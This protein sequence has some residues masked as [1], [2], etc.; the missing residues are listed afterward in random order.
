[1]GAPQLPDAC[2]PGPC[3]EHAAHVLACLSCVCRYGLQVEYLADPD[4]KK[5]L[6]E[7][8]ERT[9]VQAILLGTRKC[10]R[11]QGTGAGT[12]CQ[13]TPGKECGCTAG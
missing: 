5:G 9:K 12:Q 7:Y 2:L 6:V 10:V 3:C 11:G 13:N 1:M 8:L 4:F